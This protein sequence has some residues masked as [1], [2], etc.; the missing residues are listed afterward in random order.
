M[1]Q[2]TLSKRIQIVAD[3]SAGTQEPKQRSKEFSI[4]KLK[5]LIHEMQRPLSPLSKCCNERYCQTPFSTNHNTSANHVAN[6]SLP[7]IRSDDANVFWLEE[8][9]RIFACKTQVFL[10]KHHNFV[11]PLL[12]HQG[13]LARS[14][15]S[16]ESV[17]SS[18]T[19]ALT[20]DHGCYLAICYIC[21]RR[22]TQQ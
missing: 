17:R 14:A 12:G 8:R 21:S 20:S 22:E 19:V 6:P 16:H 4:S 3:S 1:K 7:C 18:T 13:C 5:P 2:S 11:L 10:G 15:G 9:L